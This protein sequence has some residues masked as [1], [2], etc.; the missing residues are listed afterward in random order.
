[1]LVDVHYVPGD[2]SL[3]MG[4]AVTQDQTI[5]LWRRELPVCD[6]VMVCSMDGVAPVSGCAVCTNLR[7][8]RRVAL[9]LMNNSLG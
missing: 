9:A 8:Y 7:L 1:M 5:W 6:L 3:N 2:T 4:T